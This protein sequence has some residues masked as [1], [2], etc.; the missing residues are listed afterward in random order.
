VPLEGAPECIT[1]VIGDIHVPS[2]SGDLYIVRHLPDSDAIEIYGGEHQEQLIQT[3]HY[4][5]GCGPLLVSADGRFLICSNI[6]VD[7]TSGYPQFH[8][9]SRNIWDLLTGQSL[10][11]AGVEFSPT[12]S[13]DGRYLAG[14][15][16]LRS[17]EGIYGVHLVIYDLISQ[18]SRTI[19]LIEEYPFS[20]VTFHGSYL[21]YTE[22]V[23]NSDSSIRIRLLDMETGQ[24]V[25]TYDYSDLH[26]NVVVLQAAPESDL[27]AIGFDDG[28]VTLINLAD[29]SLVHDWHAHT[30]A[31]LSL[32]FS[33][34]GHLLASAGEDGYVKVWGVL[35]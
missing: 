8:S 16:E 29:G 35:P 11:L 22:S 20:S 31:I 21:I 33:S 4:E 10:N 9:R 25:V 6:S 3:I 12:F 15:I 23:P 19:N 24:M 2:Q 34:D 28:W 18:T 7:V 17:G 27:L 13:P 5:A 32:N 26:V 30:E 14:L 1:P